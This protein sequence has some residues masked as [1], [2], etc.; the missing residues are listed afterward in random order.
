MNKVIKTRKRKKPS[1]H[2]SDRPRST[3]SRLTRLM[4]ERLNGQT[5]ERANEQANTFLLAHKSQNI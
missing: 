1:L 5:N 3:P 4:N 2:L